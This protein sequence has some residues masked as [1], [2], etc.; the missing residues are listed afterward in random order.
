MNTLCYEQR[1]EKLRAAMREQGLSALFVSH[2]A[3]RYYLSGFELHDPQINE[4]A[5][6]LIVTAD[7]NDWIC[8]DPRYLDAARRLWDE[9]RVFIYSADA[10]AQINKLLRDQVKGT[11]GFEAR[12]ISLDFFEKFSPD[13]SLQ[14]ADGIVE[15]LR[16][17]KEPEEIKR[18][19]RSCALNHT[20]MEWVPS[21]LVPGRTES[22]VSW[23]IEQFFRSHGASEL[24]FSNIVAVGPNAALPHHAPGEDIILENCPILVD[25]GCRLD[26]YCSDQTR[27]FWVGDTPAPHFLTAL[28]QTQEAQAAAIAEMRPGMLASEA[29][30]LA[31]ASFE[32][33][34]VANYFTHALGHGI[35]LETHEPPSLNPRNNMELKPGMV[36]T[37]EPGLYYPQWGGIRWEYMVLI[38]EEGV[39]VL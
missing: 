20:L 4:S 1:R 23:D 16:I 26:T 2:D 15:A 22:A 28:D 9:S 37:V 32:K 30:A 19:E 35:G 8:T 18:M 24:S 10:P 13:L 33:H 11:I 39:R 7:G 12:S 34:G 38:T 36:V 21:V 3:N 25:V 14:R 31:R 6:Y 29:Y 17:I 27:T 5:G